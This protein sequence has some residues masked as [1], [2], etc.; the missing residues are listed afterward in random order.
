MNIKLRRAVAVTA[1]AGGLIGLAAGT[2]SAKSDI[3]VS[4]SS[5]SLRVGQ[6]V[7]VRAW[8]D[9]DAARVTYVCVDERIG[10]GAWRQVGCSPHSGRALDVRVTAKQRGKEQ[11]RARLLA[12][13]GG[14][15]VT[16]R[17]SGPVTVTVR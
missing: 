8:G 1:V 6:S 14:K 10:S 15:L 5:H 17:L 9:D 13:C 2:A 7:Q 16:D 11:F 12:Q 4:V 3:T